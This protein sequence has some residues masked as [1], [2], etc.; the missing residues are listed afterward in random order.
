LTNRAA[1][2]IASNKGMGYLL[3][4]SHPVYDHSENLFV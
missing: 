2:S 3:A 4:F 1:S